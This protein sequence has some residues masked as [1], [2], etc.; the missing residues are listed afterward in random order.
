MR[1]RPPC[2]SC[3]SLGVAER[4]SESIH[5]P[6]DEI[7]DSPC[8]GILSLHSVGELELPLHKDV[9]AVAKPKRPGVKA[10]LTKIRS[11]FVALGR[12]A[13]QRA[14]RERD[15]VTVLALCRIFTY[16]V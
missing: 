3:T 8:V 16:S 6:D 2:S 5:L 12:F 7:S 10:L 9:V 4:R 1:K 11:F 13:V 15:R 14:A